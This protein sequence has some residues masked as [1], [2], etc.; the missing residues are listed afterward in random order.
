[1]PRLSKKDREDEAWRVEVH[2][3]MTQYAED[4]EVGQHLRESFPA[5]YAC[6]LAVLAVRKEGAE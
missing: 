5:V 1:M 2:R 6:L 4:A 3:Q